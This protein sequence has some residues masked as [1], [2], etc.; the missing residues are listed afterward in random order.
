VRDSGHTPKRRLLQAAAILLTLLAGPL[1]LWAL[2]R[3]AL[4][5]A[6]E[7][8]F[9]P[10][11]VVANALVGL[12]A[13]LLLWALTR[14]F[15]FSA[16]LVA[17]LHWLL[18]M[19]SRMKLELLAAPVGWHD[20]FFLSTLDRSSLA[21][22]GSYLGEQWHLVVYALGAVV[23]GGVVFFF[24][25]P[26]F[27]RFG[28]MQAGV[29]VAGV[30]LAVTLYQAAW[31]WTALLDD[32]K[33]RASP[34]NL[35]QAVLHTGLVGSLAHSHLVAK[36]K[37]LKIDEAALREAIAA[38]QPQAPA[39]STAPDRLPD[40]VVVLSESFMDPRVLSGM[41]QQP[42]AIPNVRA[43][44]DGGRGGMLM[45]PTYGGGTVRTE[46]E[47]LTGMP[48]AVLP[49]MDY[50]YATLPAKNVQGMA[51]VLRE[52]GYDT[53]AVHGNAGSFWKRRT[54]FRAMGFDRFITDAGFKQAGGVRDG[55][56][57]SD[58]SMTER[59]L[60]ELDHDDRP[61][62]VL[63]ISMENH[64]PY[65][66]RRKVR[67]PEAWSATPVPDGLEGDAERTMRN[68]LYHLGNADREFGRLVE[69]MRGRGRPF[70]VA[71]FGD[72]LP[73]MPEVYEPLGFVDGGAPEQQRVPW[74]LVSS[75]DDAPLQAASRPLHSWRLGAEVLAAAGVEDPW[76][77]FVR[78]L[79]RKA[80]Q[81]EPSPEKDALRNG[82]AAGAAARLTGRFEEFAK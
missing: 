4:G 67:D 13:L 71:F 7:A 32:K 17:G 35:S 30:A 64:G 43:L 16:L 28:P 69:E 1:L 22:F 23:V 62:F 40:I 10:R 60:H 59:I 5:V 11:A 68:Y 15:V 72:H 42:E 76:F 74:V 6:A 3:Q 27:R 36:S 25:K 50:P 75:E 19:A 44:L 39:I 38:V 63:A 48:L 49:G 45:V 82:L 51:S 41:D 56:W 46:F 81:M 14:R 31:P 52:K 9:G 61:S 70:I 21:L 53:A 33:V 47:V 2:D 34:L 77:G 66:I 20:R 73:A 65:D 24:E 12:G 58:E 18:Y 26:S 57:Y 54:V 55:L 29:F 79:G 78:E 8:Y 80:E 37:V